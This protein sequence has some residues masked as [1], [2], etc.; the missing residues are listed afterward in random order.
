MQTTSRATV[1]TLF[2]LLL[3]FGL[4]QMGNTFQGSDHR[5]GGHRSR[6]PPYY[7]GLTEGEGSRKY[8]GASMLG[9]YEADRFVLRG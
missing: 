7:G 8:F 4:M 9:V 5:G 2:G 6:D 3:G 1:A